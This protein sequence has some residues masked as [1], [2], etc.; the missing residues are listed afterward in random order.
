MSVYMRAI[1]PVRKFIIGFDPE[2]LSIDTDIRDVR[3]TLSLLDAKDKSEKAA[4]D[5]P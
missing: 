1:P 5:Q 4:E 2:K 3:S